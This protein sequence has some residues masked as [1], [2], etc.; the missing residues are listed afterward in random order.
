[1]DRM[2]TEAPNPASAQIDRLPTLRMLQ[3]IN[4][5][6]AR[7]PKAVAKELPHIAGAVDAIAARLQAGGRLIYVGA[8]TSGRL[9]VLDASEC[10]PT[11]GTP[12]GLVVG[13]IAG[14]D[15]ALREAVEGA[16]DSE[17]AGHADL[18]LLAVTGHDAVVGL[19]ASGSTPYVLGALAEARARGALTVAV[20]CNPDTPIAALADISIAPI[21]GPEVIS[22]ST[23]MKAGTAQKLVLNMLSTGTMIRLG[24]TYGNLMVDLQATNAK[25]RR[26]AQHIVAQATGLPAAEAATLLQE[27]GGEVKTAIVSHLARVT[28]AEAR[29]RLEAAGGRV[30]EALAAKK[31]R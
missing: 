9:G 29:A 23:R 4:R 12:P 15:R 2:L 25:L 17:E 14:G 1:M 6:D 30:R 5:E 21:V 19:A 10:S 31:Q 13:V 8:G 22:G 18:A 16:E 24:K 11:F 20:S 28:P 3:L 7:V 26:R 27:C